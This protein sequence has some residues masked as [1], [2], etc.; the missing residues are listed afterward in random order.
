MS[1]Y[2]DS[3]GIVHVSVDERHRFPQTGLRLHQIAPGTPSVL[4]LNF[5]VVVTH[6][7]VQQV[8]TGRRIQ[9]DVLRALVHHLS[10]LLD[11]RPAQ[12]QYGTTRVK[13]NV[14][15]RLELAHKPCAH[16]AVLNLA[17]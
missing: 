15:E 7:H 4:P 10:D 14:S 3:D 9:G 6:P 8:R 5:N 11:D 17:R 1:I 2:T 12:P 16:G 13:C